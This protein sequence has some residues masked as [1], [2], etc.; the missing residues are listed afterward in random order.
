MGSPRKISVLAA[1]L[2][3]LV[4]TSGGVVVSSGCG[5]S[6]SLTVPVLWAADQADGT[7][8]GG[9]EP[10]TVEVRSIGKPGFTLNLKDVQAKDTGDQ[11]QAA[12]ASAAAVGT[13]LS[14]SDP[15]EVDVRFDVTGPIDGPS[16]GGALTV[17]VLAAVRDQA[18][19][20]GVTMTGTINPDGSIGPVTNV[21]TKV[22]SAAEAGYDT[23]LIPLGTEVELDP[24]T[25]EEVD[26]VKFG[27][28]LDVEVRVVPD[29]GTAYRAFTGRNLAPGSGR[30]PR[31]TGAVRRVA[32]ETT[33]ELDRRI[34]SALEQAPPGTVGSGACALAG[35]ALEA[36]NG[37]DTA[38]AYALGVD[39]LKEVERDRLS[40]EVD[41]AFGRGGVPS[42]ARLLEDRIKTLE[43]KAGATTAGAVRRAWGG[44][45]QQLLVPVALGWVSYS[46]ALLEV[47][48]ERLARKEG[49]D[50]EALAGLAGVVA[51]AGSSIEVFGPD[52]V[53]A[54]LAS[55]SPRA[56]RK[57][58]RAVADYLSGYTNFLIRGGRASEQ[59]F[60]D[61]VRAIG[62]GGVP[63]YIYPAFRALGRSV[64][65]IP[66]E[67][68]P[69]DREMV[70]AS[71]AISYF[72]IGSTLV[73]GDSILGLDSFGLGESIS[74]GAGSELLPNAT[75]GA[76]STVEYWSSVLQRR[77]LSAGYPVWS[78]RWGRAGLD[79][80]RGTDRETTGVVLALEEAWYSAI[81]CFMLGGITS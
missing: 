40:A 55:R 44:Y 12:S 17:G 72:V 49:L 74:E 34:S 52:A 14:G 62:L 54:A 69:L 7:V 21:L 23:V 75:E 1:S 10:A 26:I 58:E 28:S 8:A 25:G 37:G 76:L 27:R 41:S 5:A 29:I 78:S 31:L 64:D 79:A 9:I 60:E 70:Q 59:Y 81:G 45:E 63:E 67:T 77:G 20:S 51:D 65:R 19:R 36:G 39:A 18:L 71:R 3:A 73:S 46:T 30:P 16:G 57:S 22:E 4:A 56:P 80:F 13:L 24:E 47:V 2:L 43:G 53:E 15:N 66:K 6:D 61:V 32:K 50:R 33:V 42:A 38:R 48:R 11:W 68:N 35:Q